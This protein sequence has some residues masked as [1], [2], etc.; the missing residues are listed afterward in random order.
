MNEKI[1]RKKEWHAIKK[2]EKRAESYQ[3]RKKEK[4]EWSS[5]E[6]L[7]TFFNDVNWATVIKSGLICKA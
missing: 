3:E 5:N 7:E 6:I 2:K 4:A 1:S